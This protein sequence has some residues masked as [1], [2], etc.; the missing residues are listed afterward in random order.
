MSGPAEELQER[1]VRALRTLDLAD[2]VERA[3]LML[4]Y[5]AQLQHWNRAYNLTA[6]RDPSQMLVQHVFDSLAVVPAL[7][8]YRKGSSTAVADIGSGAGLPGIILGICEP[9]WTITCVDTVGKKAAF[10]RQVAGVL[11]LANVRSVQARVESLESLQADIVISRAFA[12][13]ADFVRVASHHC[14]PGGVMLAMKGQFP[15]TERAALESTTDWCVRRSLSL[16]VPEMEAQRCL[17][18]LGPKEPND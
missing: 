16:H 13:L 4:G 5:L 9:G 6:V 18:E 15:D 8:A 2:E 1:L 11:G 17:L 10:V 14:G 3:P 12:S 7:R